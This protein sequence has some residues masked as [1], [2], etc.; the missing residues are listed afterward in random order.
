MDQEYNQDK[1]SMAM[2]VICLSP[3]RA[4]DTITLI[5][6]SGVIENDCHL[7]QGF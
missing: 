1:R 2:L 7:W 6:T 3:V 4:E 5:G